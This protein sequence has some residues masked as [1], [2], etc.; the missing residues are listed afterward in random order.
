[1]KLRY[2]I[3]SFLMVGV[4]LVIYSIPVFA[5]SLDVNREI[6]RRF[7]ERG[8]ALKICLDNV[9]I[10]PSLA[11]PIYKVDFMG[12]LKAKPMVFANPASYERLSNILKKHEITGKIDFDTLYIQA[13]GLLGESTALQFDEFVREGKDINV[14]NIFFLY[15]KMIRPQIKNLVKINDNAQLSK[16][17]EAFV[18]YVMSSRPDFKKN[19]IENVKQFLLDMPIDIASVFVMCVAKYAENSKEF[20]Y[21]TGIYVRMMEDKKFKEFYQKMVDTSSKNRKKKG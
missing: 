12:T 8:A 4:L 13:A 21:M 2:Y 18:T 6:A 3:V 15:T 20:K 19:E 1:M 9:E 10:D 5:D 11:L 17:M 16:I 14:K 7:T